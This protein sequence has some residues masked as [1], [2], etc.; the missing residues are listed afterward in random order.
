M[1]ANPD[2]LGRPTGT[3][4]D[5]EPREDISEGLQALESYKKKDPTKKGETKSFSIFRPLI[6]NAIR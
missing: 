2:D 4:G 6:Q 1:S 3:W 5:M